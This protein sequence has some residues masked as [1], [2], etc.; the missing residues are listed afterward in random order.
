MDIPSK[1]EALKAESHWYDYWM[2][3]D[4]F[5]STPDEREPYTIVIPPPNVTGVLHMGHMLNNTIQDVLIRRARLMGKNACWVPG[6]DHASIATEAKVVAKLKAEGIDKADLSR[7]EFLKHAWEWTDEYGGVILEQLKKLGASCDWNRTKFTMDDDMY[8]SVI[9]VFVDLFNKGLIY[10]GHRMVNWDPEAQTTLSDEEVIYE[11]KQ[12]LLYYLSYPI[13]GSEERVT[14]ATTRPET[15]L[16]DTAICINP[17]DERYRHLKGKKVVV[18]ISGRVIPII[19][20]EYVDIEFGTGCLKI[21]PAHDINDKALGEKH[22]LETIDIFNAN[23]TLNSFG[24]HYEGK[25]RFVVR[26]EITKELEEKGFLVKKENYVNKVGTSER[27]KAVIEPRLSDQWFLKMEELV[28]PAIDSVLKTEEVK[29]FPKKFENTYR[30][31]MENIRDWNISRQ[32]WWGQQIPA[33]YFGDGQED[34]VVAETK[35]DA[36]KLAQEKSGNANLTEVDLRQDEDALDTWFSSWLWPISVFNGILE[37]DNKEVNYYYPTNDL[38]TGPDII[39]FWVARMIISGYEYRDERPFQNVYFTGLVRDKQRRKMSKSLGNSP[40]ALKLIEDYGADGVRVGLLLSSAAGNDLMF[41]EDL[42]QQ[43][44]NFANKIWNG[45]RLLK[46]WEIADL[47]QP[48]ASRLGIEWYKA[49]FNKTLVE[50]EDHFSKY[51]ISDALMAI[52][53]LVWDDYSSWLLEIIK[54]DYQKP[55]DR[56][57]YE[58]VIDIFEQNLKLLHPF[59]PFLTEEVWQH[60]TERTPENAL[61]VAQWP[62]MQTVDEALIESF[63]IAAEVVSGVRNI[64]K[65]KNIPM[66]ESLELMVLNE[67]NLAKTWDVV[68]EKLTNVAEVSYVDATV[69]GALSFRVKSNEYFVPMSGAIDVEAEIKKIEEELKYTKGFLKSVEKKLSNER[70]VSNAPEKVIAVERQKQADA[71][72]KIETLEKSLASLG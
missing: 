71:E 6:M 49:K 10:R 20:D 68:I 50:I 65:E 3:H 55:I 64:R 60:I 22:N 34:F 46:G 51:R 17:N 28:K 11:E 5:S 40:D 8:K 70:F 4:Y 39:F 7:E 54:P 16:G 61:V 32:L 67:G 21:T 63:D 26:K 1:Y 66:K 23:A 2:E 24:L 14:I 35:T 57:T 45:F 42:C 59:M 48:K 36:L 43:G 72:A 38:V 62:K 56:I 29:F 37:P 18:P 12:G 30:H 15:I 33:F 53:K 69:D 47:P 41:D 9:K 19:E 13:E 58:A 44:K 31:W 52:Y 25:D 27:T